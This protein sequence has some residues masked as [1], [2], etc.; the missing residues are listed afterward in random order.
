MPDIKGIS[1]FGSGGLLYYYLG[2]AQFIQEGYNLEELD[3]KC[4]SGGCL[5]AVVLSIF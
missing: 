4:V 5:P 3:Y 1:F 2:I